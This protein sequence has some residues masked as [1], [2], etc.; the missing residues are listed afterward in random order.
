[1]MTKDTTP[2]QPPRFILWDERAALGDIDDANCHCCEETREACVKEI[3]EQGYPMV[4]NDTHNDTFEHYIP[5][6]MRKGG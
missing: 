1:M 6:A 5:K 2:R 4:I 3:E